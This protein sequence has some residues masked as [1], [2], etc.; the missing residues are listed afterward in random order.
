MFD[1]NWPQITANVA[2]FKE[3]SGRLSTSAET[4][5]LG[6]AAMGLRQ[7]M[8]RTEPV[9]WLVGNRTFPALTLNVVLFLSQIYLDTDKENSRSQSTFCTKPRSETG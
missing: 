2:S 8:N 1:Q 6:S 9:G 5:G 4:G 7:S 3:N